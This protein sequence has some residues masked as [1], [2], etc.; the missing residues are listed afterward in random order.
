MIV[1]VEPALVKEP[2]DS[3]LYTY[4]SYPPLI[5]V[6]V[7]SIKKESVQEGFNPLI[8]AYSNPNVPVSG[9]AFNTAIIPFAAASVCPVVG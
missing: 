3:C 6:S 5:I 2:P 8:S 1:N 7:L 4:P 9:F